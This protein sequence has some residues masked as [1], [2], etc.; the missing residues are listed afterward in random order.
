MDGL[1]NKIVPD[2]LNVTQGSLVQPMPFPVRILPRSEMHA[3]TV[4][5]AWEACQMLLDEE[6]QWLDVPQEQRAQPQKA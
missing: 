2:R 6:G 1:G 5:K 3:S 4:T